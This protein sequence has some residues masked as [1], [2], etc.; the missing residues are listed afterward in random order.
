MDV[1]AIGASTY[2][3]PIEVVPGTNGMHPSLAIT[4]NSLSGHSQM[5]IHWG[6]QGLSSITRCTQTN[7]YDGNIQQLTFNIDDRFSLD[8]K[9]MV[10]LKG[11]R[12]YSSDAL[13]AFENDDLSRIQRVE[14]IDGSFYFVDTL[15]DGHI[16]EY[17]ATNDACQMVNGKVLS[18]MMNKITDAN[19][20]YITYHYSQSDGEIWIDHIDYTF[21][22]QALLTSAYASI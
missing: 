7:Y 6:L 9:R 14:R 2:S 11:E 22:A 10:L 5:G 21:N 15:A 18:W 3:I 13:Y 19:N 4:Y 16:V 12:Y 17:G 8:G 20:N 1:N